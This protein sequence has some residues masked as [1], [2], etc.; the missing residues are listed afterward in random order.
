[1]A[2]ARFSFLASLTCSTAALVLLGSLSGTIPARADDVV[3]EVESPDNFVVRQKFA[4]NDGVTLRPIG[5]L[6][7][8]SQSGTAI[9]VSISHLGSIFA[10]NRQVLKVVQPTVGEDRA[11]VADAHSDRSARL[12]LELE[13]ADRSE[14][15][16]PGL[17][18][19]RPWAEPPS[20]P[21]DSRRRSSPGG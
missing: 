19:R 5:I 11:Q 4:A 18:L 13:D 1:M 16:P 15:Q 7:L 17:D 10:E 14:H 6:E 2:A 9:G 3:V 20:T 8:K 21:G 12:R